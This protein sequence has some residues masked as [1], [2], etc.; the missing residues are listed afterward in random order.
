MI[1]DSASKVLSMMRQEDTCTGDTSNWRVFH[2]DNLQ[3]ESSFW[4]SGAFGYVDKDNVTL[5]TIPI[6]G[7]VTG[8]QYEF[9]SWCLL[10]ADNY[11]SPYFELVYLDAGGQKMGDHKIFTKECK[12]NLGLWFRAGEYVKLPEHCA[13]IVCLLRNDDHNYIAIDEILFRSAG[14]MVISKDK[15]GRTL[16]NNHIFRTINKQ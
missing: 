9:S 14:G 2:L 8:K 13:K 12:D 7:N 4:G 1:A 10:P 16:V 15:N 6:T 3:A 5:A 11:K